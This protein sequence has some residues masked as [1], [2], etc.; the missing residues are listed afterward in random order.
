MRLGTSP[1]ERIS[2]LVLP[3]LAG[4]FRWNRAALDSSC[5]IRDQPPAGQAGKDRGVGVIKDRD[6]SHAY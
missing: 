5:L 6:L 2:D 1:S 3:R 4:L